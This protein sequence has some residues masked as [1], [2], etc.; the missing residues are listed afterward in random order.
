MSIKHDYARYS[1][2]LSISTSVFKRLARS[3][4]H[5]YIIVA[6]TLVS[7]GESIADH[8]ANWVLL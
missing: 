4:Y 1:E 5:F 6:L 8:L 3:M 7:C 2:R